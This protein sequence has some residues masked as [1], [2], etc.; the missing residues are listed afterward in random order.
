MSSTPKSLST[1]L[2]GVYS[3]NYEKQIRAIFDSLPQYDIQ[4]K[5]DQK[6]LDSHLDLC[7]EMLKEIKLAIDDR[8]FSDLS[9]DSP[10]ERALMKNKNEKFYSYPN[11][12]SAYEDLIFY[13][14]RIQVL[15][16][17]LESLKY[18]LRVK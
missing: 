10:I 8:T 9:L 5:L 11:K 14:N 4:S 13:K 12:F 7:K 16:N 6:R 1:I 17:R 18:P 2:Y 3:N 15:K